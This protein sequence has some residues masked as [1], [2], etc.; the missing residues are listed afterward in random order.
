MEDLKDKVAAAHRILHQQG[1]ADWLGHASAR[2]PGTD[3]FLTK[4]LWL[5]LQTTT[6]KNIVTVNLDGK[7]VE[8][9]SKP[10]AES[11]LHAEVYRA[12]RDVGG[13]VH[14]H[15][16]WAVIFGAAGRDI[17]PLCH[18]G[19]S[20]VVAGPL[21]VYESAELITRPEQGKD[22]AQKLGK[23][24][25]C[26]LR[27]HGIVVV[28]KT[29]EQAVIR[30]INLERL[31]EMTYRAAQM[32]TPHAIPPDVIQAYLQWEDEYITRV[33]GVSTEERAWEYFSS[34]VKL[35]K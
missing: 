16:K 34:L 20:S 24:P 14:T 18:P 33:S 27:N 23:H 6:R 3:R 26:H 4:G 31:A 10:P 15:Q 7:L 12:R 2:V 29:L 13:V 8:G 30:A 9:D 19:N 28:G 32:G 1:L 25:A 21:P 17:L 22:V 11:V 35:A 5:S